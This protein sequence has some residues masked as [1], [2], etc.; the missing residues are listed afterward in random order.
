MNARAWFY[1]QGFNDS[2][3]REKTMVADIPQHIS[4]D[5]FLDVQ[6]AVVRYLKHKLHGKLLTH[7]QGLEF[8]KSLT[9]EI[10]FKEE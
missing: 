10:E 6:E 7:E 4:R 3:S 5:T 1:S 8:A 2:A 9:E